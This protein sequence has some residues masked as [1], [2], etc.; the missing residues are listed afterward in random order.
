MHLGCIEKSP[1]REYLLKALG[2]EAMN[3]TLSTVLLLYWDSE[4]LGP[5]GLLVPIVKS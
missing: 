2:L 3:T 1:P 4:V 5:A